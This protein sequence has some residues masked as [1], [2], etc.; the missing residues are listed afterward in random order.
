MTA[1]GHGPEVRLPRYLALDP[2]DPF[3]GRVVG[4]PDRADIPFPAEET[5]IVEFYAR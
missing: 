5:A 3:R 1:V 4:L 2:D